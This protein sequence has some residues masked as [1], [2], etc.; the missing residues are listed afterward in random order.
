MGDAGRLLLVAYVLSDPLPVSHA[1]QRPYLF[2]SI[3][4]EV[5]SGSLNSYK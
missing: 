4:G 2:E 1:R 3:C 5:V